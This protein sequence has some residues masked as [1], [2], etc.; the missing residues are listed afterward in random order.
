MND[1]QYYCQAISTVLFVYDLGY[2]LRNDRMREYAINFFV[3][4]GTKAVSM[5]FP[6]EFMVADN[7]AI[8]KV[9]LEAEVAFFEAMR[10]QIVATLVEDPAYVRYRTAVAIQSAADVDTLYERAVSEARQSQGE[11]AS[12]SRQGA[13]ST[14]TQ[15]CG[16]GCRDLHM[17]ARDLRCYD[18]SSRTCRK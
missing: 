13:S 5:V 3:K 15:V 4:Y 18:N 10:N 2:A 11:I 14:V 12:A 6:P 9:M 7:V 17:V 16:S 1:S 8:A